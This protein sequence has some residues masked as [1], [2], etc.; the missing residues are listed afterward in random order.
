MF[1][2]HLTICL[3]FKAQS[4]EEEVLVHV[5]QLATVSVLLEDV[6]GEPNNKAIFNHQ[7][8]WH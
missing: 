1:I 3:I 7:K 5:L 8:P 6:T 4:N 2:V